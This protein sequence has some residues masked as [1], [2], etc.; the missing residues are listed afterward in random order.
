MAIEH[1]EENDISLCH[2]LQ[3]FIAMTPQSPLLRE[4]EKKPKRKEKSTK[5]R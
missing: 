2:S 3:P 5:T 4:E 1:R